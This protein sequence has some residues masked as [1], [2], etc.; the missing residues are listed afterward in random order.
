MAY[1]TAPNAAFVIHAGDMVDTAHRD[2]EWAGL[3]WG[4]IHSVDSNSCCWKS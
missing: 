1:Q 3:R 4:F 2:Y